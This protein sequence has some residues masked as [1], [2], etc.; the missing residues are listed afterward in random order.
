MTGRSDRASPGDDAGIFLSN[1]PAQ[2]WLADERLL[3][4]RGTS[5]TWRSSAIP[6]AHRGPITW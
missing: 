4:Q 1:F 5:C 6:M 2:G 3:V